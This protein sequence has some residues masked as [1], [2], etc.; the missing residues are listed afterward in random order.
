MSKNFHENKA[1]IQIIF[2]KSLEYKYIL[3][4]ICRKILTQISFSYIL[5]CTCPVLNFLL[6]NIKMKYGKGRMSKKDKNY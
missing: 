1:L 6:S 4:I 2:K 5:E 3:K